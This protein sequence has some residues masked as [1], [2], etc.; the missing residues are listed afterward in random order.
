MR[1]W[2]YQEQAAQS[3]LVLEA[4]VA[5]SVGV[6]EYRLASV[7]TPR[8]AFGDPVPRSVFLTD[9]YICNHR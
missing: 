4:D 5:Y 7:R 8:V 3:P 9:G 1:N 2:L 6:L